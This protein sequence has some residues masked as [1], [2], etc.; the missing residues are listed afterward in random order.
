MS[1]VSMKVGASHSGRERSTISES[2]VIEEDGDGKTG[3]GLCESA[4]LCAQYEMS[5]GVIL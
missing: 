2:K 5:G 3:G 1:S 4:S